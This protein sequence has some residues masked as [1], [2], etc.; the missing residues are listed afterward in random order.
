MLLADVLMEPRNLK[1]VLGKE[2]SGMRLDKV[3]A[4]L[5]PSFSRAFLQQAIR[6][7]HVLVDGKT[8]RPRDPVRGGECV[9][10]GLEHTP[11][12][13]DGAASPE[14]LPLT[15]CYEDEAVIVVEKD[16]GI[17]VHPAAGHRSGTLVNALLHH[18][19]DL[20]LLPR[21]GIVHR[22]DKDTSGLLLSAKTREAH[23]SLVEQMAAREINRSYLCLVCGQV[24]CGGRI[25]AA[26]GRHP[27]DRK[28]MAVV[29]GGRRAVTHYRVEMRFR[30]YTLL[31]VTLETGRT[32]QIRVHMAH[33]GHPV[34]GDPLYGKKLRA[35]PG[36]TPAA[37]LLS[38][39]KRQALHAYYLKFRH[40]STAQPVVQQNAPPA[41]MQLLLNT[42]EANRPPQ[43][44]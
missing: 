16:A 11:A 23:K 30:D 21:A 7:G 36:D 39:F 24:A 3:L 29:A 33:I 37:E 18:C 35:L 32:H 31:R 19:P 43:Q 42:L 10:L 26:V 17:V 27:R 1:A 14:A 44:A 40:P 2:Y 22:L 20:K 25:D 15:V 41:D 12:D 5:F 34:F 38:G 8:R 28:R 4:G 6:R 9:V 13:E